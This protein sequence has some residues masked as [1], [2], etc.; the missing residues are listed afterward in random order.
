METENQKVEREKRREE[1]QSQF[2]LGAILRDLALLNG[3][4][5]TD[6]EA[7]EDDSEDDQTAKRETGEAAVET[8]KPAPVESI[9]EKYAHPRENRQ[10]VKREAE[11]ETVEDLLGVSPVDM[12]SQVVG[13]CGIPEIGVDEESD[14]LEVEEAEEREGGEERAEERAERVEEEWGCDVDF[15]R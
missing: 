13:N 10:S 2:D 11:G 9:R 12:R 6:E 7:D 8:E 1:V 4:M 14:R 15:R 3:D 5:E